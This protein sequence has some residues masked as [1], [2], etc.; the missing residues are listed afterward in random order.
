MPAFSD[1]Y[2]NPD[3]RAR[4]EQLEKAHKEWGKSKTGDSKGNDPWLKKDEKT[5]RE[6]NE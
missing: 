1:F 2:S 3:A 5:A 4:R 6:W